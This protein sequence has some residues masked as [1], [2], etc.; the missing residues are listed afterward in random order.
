MSARERI[1]TEPRSR[2]VLGRGLFLGR[3]QARLKG[4]PGRHAGT[5]V[6][7][8]RLTASALG[9]APRA[10][11]R[12]E[13]RGIE[14]AGESSMPSTSAGAGRLTRRVRV[15]RPHR[16][17]RAA[18]PTADRRAARAPPSAA[19]ASVVAARRDDHDLGVGARR[20]RRSHVPGSARRRRR[21]RR[22]RRRG[23]PSR[24]PSAR[25]RTSGAVH[26]I[27]ATRGRGARAALSVVVHVRTRVAQRVEQRLAPSRRPHRRARRARMSAY[28]PSSVVPPSVHA[29]RGGGPRRA[30]SARTSR[31]LTAHTSHSACVSSTSGCSARDRA[32]RRARTAARP[33]A[34]ARARRRR[35]LRV[36][37][38]RGT[39]LA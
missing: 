28:T 10:R 16:A 33:A 23:S 34:T 29:R 30:A 22:C 36:G 15:E 17:P 24:A 4:G 5:R 19:R 9:R 20:T 11:G 21:A 6:R 7:A 32:S 18:T 38:V 31:S 35:P 37:A 2:H 1:A 3:S 12:R 27:T 13:E 14:D 26:S 39:A 8:A 25:R